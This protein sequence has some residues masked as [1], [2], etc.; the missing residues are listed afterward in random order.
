[1]SSGEFTERNTQGR[2]AGLQDEANVADRLNL[3]DC[4]KE[5]ILIPGYVQPHGV[6]LALTEPDLTIVQVSE[7]AE[8]FNTYLLCA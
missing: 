1:M 6:L 3:T 2:T 8:T 7:S 5:P 4:D